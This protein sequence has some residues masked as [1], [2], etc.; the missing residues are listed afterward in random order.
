M[1]NETKLKKKH[2]EKN[3]LNIFFLSTHY[4]NV[5]LNTRNYTS[6]CKARESN[7]PYYRGSEDKNITFS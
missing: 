2:T 4:K 7:S 5:K 6:K 1:E 3:E